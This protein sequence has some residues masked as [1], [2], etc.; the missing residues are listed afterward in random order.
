MSG[1]KSPS[2]KGPA[3]E[4]GARPAVLVV[5][6]GERGGA[7]IDW[8]AHEVSERARRSGRF[9]DA[10]TCFIS[11]EPSLDCALAE[12]SPGPAV[13][14]P[15]FMSDGYFVLRRIPESIERSG[16]ARRIDVS[17]PLGLHPK[18]AEVITQLAGVTARSNSV[19]PERCRLMLVA[20]GSKHDPASRNATEKLAAEISVNNAFA[21]VEVAFLEEDPFLE[22][23]IATIAG[24]AIAFGLFAS[25]GMHGAADLPNAV[26][27]CGRHDVYLAP[28]LSR[29][30]LLLDLVCHD[31]SGQA[32][33]F[34][35]A[36]QATPA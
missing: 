33:R 11:K 35:P 2:P 14:Y 16:G 28:P 27:A 20:H 1:T 15:M 8:L 3:T 5:A 7:G 23:R 9:R 25:E 34:F 19:A 17:T 29:S 26:D 32:E 36:A 31:L 12:L 13:I 18:L 6:H 21:G 24:P 10:K 22:D 30:S 4:A